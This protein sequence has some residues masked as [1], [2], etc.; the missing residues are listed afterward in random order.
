MHRVIAIGAFALALAG[1]AGAP[2]NLVIETRGPMPTL[3]EA[4][5]VAHVALRRTLKDYDSMKDFAVVG[6]IRPIS[7]TNLSYNFE[8]AWLLC[9]EFNAKNSYG[10]YTGIQERGFPMRYVAGHLTV[11]SPV[12]WRTNNTDGC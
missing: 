6:D 2:R 4:L 8:E 5:A 10:G 7:A 3:Q 11:L 12:N 9:V 1:C